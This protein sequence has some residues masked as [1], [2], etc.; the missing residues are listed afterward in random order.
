MTQPQAPPLQIVALNT[1]YK[2]GNS[3]H[4][5]D[6]IQLSRGTSDPL[7]LTGFKISYTNS[8]GHPAGEILLDNYILKGPD[9]YLAYAES[10]QFQKF[11][12]DFLYNFGSSGL[13]S[14]GGMLQLSYGGEILNEICWGR[15]QCS[16]SY[17]AF[18]TDFER[19]TSLVRCVGPECERSFVPLKYYP[20]EE[21][22]S[23]G[24][25]VDMLTTPGFCKDLLITEI[26]STYKEDPSEQFVE[27][28]NAGT[29]EIKLI[30]CRL[31]Y[32]GK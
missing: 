16:D 18:S 20:Y 5:Y 26:F 13:A 10:P 25:F 28:F 29:E 31:R 30:N 9:L 27:L 22:F 17:P 23:T 2:D 11:N 4:N 3:D 21:A 12:L 14:T 1:G 8:L 6:F 24:D 19:N 7:D 15:L 32:R